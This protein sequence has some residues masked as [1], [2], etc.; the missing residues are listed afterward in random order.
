[1][2]IKETH[3]NYVQV[4]KCLMVQLP[5]KQG[6]SLASANK[7]SGIDL[8]KY[9]REDIIPLIHSFIEYCNS[10]KVDPSLML[11][12]AGM[13]AEGEMEEEQALDIL[14]NCPEFESRW[15]S[16]V[17]FTLKDALKQIKR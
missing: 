15:N 4:L 1:M 5:L 7:R 12:L 9:R 11:R 16:I 3:L 10:F 2:S 6:L 8:Y 14:T 17:E 13:V